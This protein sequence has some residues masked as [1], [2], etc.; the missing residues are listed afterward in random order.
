VAGTLV[1]AGAARA[2]VLVLN[3]DVA[4]LVKGA[5]LKDDA[6]VDIPAKKSIRVLFNQS[7]ATKLIQGPSKG[8]ISAYAPTNV[9]KVISTYKQPSP[10]DTMDYQGAP[11]GQPPPTGQG[12][13]RR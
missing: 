6:V 8:P 12:Q 1:A 5:T 11:L 9:G 10:R 3:S 13:P 4:G 2:D 7:K